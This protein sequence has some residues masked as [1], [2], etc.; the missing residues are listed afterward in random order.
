MPGQR[1]PQQ[2]Y[3]KGLDDPRSLQPNELARIKSE[4]TASFPGTPALSF[5]ENVA[6]FPESAE[7]EYDRLIG[8]KPILI[9]VAIFGWVQRRRLYWAAGPNGEDVAWQTRAL[10]PDNRTSN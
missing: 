7:Q 8:L 1:L 6:S 5:L 10:P 9:D 3:R 4:L 2:G